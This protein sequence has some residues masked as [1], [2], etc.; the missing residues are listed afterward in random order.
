MGLADVTVPDGYILVPTIMGVASILFMSIDAFVS[1]AQ[2]SRAIHQEAMSIQ[3][4]ENI[5]L[6]QW[7]VAAAP[8]VSSAGGLSG[9]SV[10]V[11]GVF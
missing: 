9:A 6:F 2:A 8:V 3:H 11:V 10:G 4:A 5:K 7:T 1:G